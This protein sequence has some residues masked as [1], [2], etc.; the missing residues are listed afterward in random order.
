MT[1]HFP[2]QLVL[3]IRL[4]A[5]LFGT[6]AAPAAELQKEI[7]NG[8]RAKGHYDEAIDYL[9]HARAN[10]STAKTFLETIDYEQAVTQIDAAAGMAETHRDKPLQLAQESLTK[11]LSDHPQHALAAAA[12]A[13]FGTVLFDRGRL[14]RMLAGQFEGQARQE[15]LEAARRLLRQAEEQWADIDQAAEVELKQIVF[16]RGDDIKRSEARDQIHR[17]QLQARLARAWAQC[18]MG[19]TY[20]ADSAERTSTL[21]DAGHRFD[22]IHDQQ[23]ERLAGFYARLG[24]G[25]CWKNLGESEKA[26]AIFEELLGLP[27]DPAD[28]HALRGKAAMQALEIALQPEVK[29]YKQGLDIAQHWIGVD[30]RQ[31]ASGEAGT[32]SAE[33]DLAIHCLGGEVALA[34]AKPLSAASLAQSGLR[35]Q[36]IDW[37][38]QQFNIVAAVAGPYQ[39]K[40]KIHLLDPALGP[41][42]TSEPGT[43]ADARN[44][45]KAALDRFLAA[46]AEQKEAART[47]TGNDLDSQRQR[48]QQI[49]TAQNEALKFCRLAMDLRTAAVAM[50]EYDTLRY[51][52][53]YLRYVTGEL[54]EAAAL[55][56]SLAQSSSDSP[57]ARQAARIGLAAREA[58]LRCATDPSRPTAVERL[59]ALAEKIIERWGNHAEA[60]DARGVLLD[61]ALRDGQLENAEQYLQ[62][63]SNASPRRGEAE[64]NLGQALWRQAQ[65]LL[66]TST[67]EHDHAAEAEKIIVRATGLLGDGLARCRKAIDSGTAKEPGED[68]RISRGMDCQSVLRQSLSA[69]MLALAQIHITEGRPVE[70]IALLEDPSTSIVTQDS[71]CLALL[72]YVATGQLDKAKNCLQTLQASLPPTANANAPRQMLQTCVGFHRL[73]KQRLTRFR[74]RRQD[75]LVKKIVQEFDTF[76]ASLAQGPGI[77]SFFVLA[78]RAEA[79]NGLAEGLDVG[80]PALLPEAEKHYRQAVAAFQEILHRVAKEANFSP[81]AEVTI[82]LR[83]ELARCLRRLSDNSQSLS[84]LLEIL[85]DHPLM[86]DAQVEAAYTYQSWG[87]EKPEYLEMAIQGGKRY[88]EVWGWGEL[89]RRV[90]SEARFRQVFHEARYNLALCR[91][92][93][94]QIATDRPQRARLAE[95]AENDILATRRLFPDM[96]G[97]VWYDRYNGLLKRIQRLADQPVVGLQCVGSDAQK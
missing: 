28:F 16:V 7:L 43:F 67:L 66:R 62:Q 71:C 21:Q 15:H 41:A 8:L 27:D 89:A 93:Q 39:A 30:H 53:T 54:D 4:A 80:G 95:A 82:A 75:D 14:Q 84:Q 97:T 59:Q 40:A 32:T 23:R 26:F 46:Q 55:G 56:E 77:G 19:Q 22:L 74:D 96:G 24:R 63:I 44:R 11:F 35:T 51:Y 2:R 47:G 87:D 57:T 65:Q 78:W 38:R 83:I 70:A 58:L 1:C 33:V 29:K 68:A 81:A 10:P 3:S 72:A 61:L 13:Q 92:R 79:Y 20:P 42:E 12:R 5:I 85:K 76:L 52:L 37:A 90:Q 34:Y 64:L 6:I 91:L 25:F 31:A 49:A 36:Q 50:E 69:A 18:E 88:Q 86:V 94:A 48:R 17:R 73:L 60:D 9:Q 45:A